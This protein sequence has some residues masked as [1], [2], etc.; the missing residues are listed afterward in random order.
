MFARVEYRANK[1]SLTGLTETDGTTPMTSLV[2][3]YQGSS[4]GASKVGC[5]LYFF[6]D[7]VKS[8]EKI[9]TVATLGLQ[10]ELNNIHDAAQLMTVSSVTPPR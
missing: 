10:L 5:E 7:D 2:T 3:S 9:R 8:C 6:R 1:G 4:P